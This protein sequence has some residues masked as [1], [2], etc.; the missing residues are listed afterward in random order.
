VTLCLFAVSALPGFIY[1]YQIRRLLEQAG[2]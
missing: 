1:R 2:R